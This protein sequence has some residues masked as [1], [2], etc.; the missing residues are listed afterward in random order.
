MKNKNQYPTLLKEYNK[1][2]NRIYSD[3][4]AMKTLMQS[5]FFQAMIAD[6]DMDDELGSV[7]GCMESFIDGLEVFKQE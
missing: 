3:L 2:Q 4:K 7:Y 6:E 5:K 1:L